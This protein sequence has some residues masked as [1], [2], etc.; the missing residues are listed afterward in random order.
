MPTCYLPGYAMWT[1]ADE[2]LPP[3]VYHQGGETDINQMI[4]WTSVELYL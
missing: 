4:N 2:I 1:K 3:E